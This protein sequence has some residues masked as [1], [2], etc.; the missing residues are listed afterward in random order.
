MKT[1]LTAPDSPRV[2]IHMV[3]SLDGII[4]KS[5]NSIDW[6]ETE[7]HYGPGIEATAEEQTLAGIDCYVMGSHTY[8]LAISLADQHGWP[9][10]G[11]PSYV[12]TS[13]ELPITQKGVLLFSGDPLQLLERCRENHYQNIW[14]LGGAALCTS[15]L[16]LN[17]VKEIHVTI[18]P[19]LLGSGLR[20]FEKLSGDRP[21]HLIK[22]RASKAGTI[23]LAYE[24]KNLTLHSSI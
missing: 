3:C 10:G 6:F 11:K 21:L 18:L 16:N 13:R 1:D 14:V 17:L 12:M 5:D 2:C 7:D 24:L 22:N 15:F 8:E 4:A 19:I 23:E 20:L 9:Y